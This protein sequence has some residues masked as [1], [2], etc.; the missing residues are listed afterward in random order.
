MCYSLSVQEVQHGLTQSIWRRI[1]EYSES[2]V[3]N[4]H[5]YLISEDSTFLAV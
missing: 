1:V 5:T 3:I 4:S 2:N